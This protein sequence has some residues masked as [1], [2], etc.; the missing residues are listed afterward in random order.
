MHSTE[1]RCYSGS[2]MRQFLVAAGFSDTRFA[3][4]VADRSIVTA[5]R[6]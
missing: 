6:D 4:T 1:G 3:P 2:E 5:I